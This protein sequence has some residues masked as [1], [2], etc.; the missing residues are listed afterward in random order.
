ML[1]GAFQGDFVLHVVADAWR[2]A[3]D[4]ASNMRVEG[5]FLP[6]RHCDHP[7]NEPPRIRRAKITVLLG[8]KKN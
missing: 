7:H 2:F 1:L 6:P 5:I 4:V 8:R 3:F